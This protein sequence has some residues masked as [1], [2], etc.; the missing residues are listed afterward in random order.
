[1]VIQWAFFRGFAGVQVQRKWSSWYV[2]PLVCGISFEKPHVR[3][4]GQPAKSKKQAK[5]KKTVPTKSTRAEKPKRSLR[6]TVSRFRLLTNL[7]VTPGW[8]LIRRL[9]RTISLHR[10]SLN[11]S[12]G[13]ADPS[14]TGSLCGYLHALKSWGRAPFDVSVQPEFTKR[15][16]KGQISLSLHLH[17]SYA[18]LALLQFAGVVAWRF[19]IEFA[20]TTWLKLHHKMSSPKREKSR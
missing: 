15:G 8:A 2:Y 17:H 18:L 20:G 5:Q 19:A 6:E 16:L 14:S 9:P 1:M 11:G 7:L 12:L 3:L 10:C 4:T 13:L